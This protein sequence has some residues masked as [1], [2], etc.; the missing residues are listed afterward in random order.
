MC[1]DNWL[2]LVMCWCGFLVAVRCFFVVASLSLIV[3]L[4]VASVLQLLFA[5]LLLSCNQFKEKQVACNTV[6]WQNLGAKSQHVSPEIVNI[7]STFSQ[8]LVNS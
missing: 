3:A 1:V 6:M 4:C 7:S 2:Q 8:Q 5:S